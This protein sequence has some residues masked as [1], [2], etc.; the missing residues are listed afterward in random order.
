MDLPGP[1]QVERVTLTAAMHAAGGATTLIAV[2]SPG[3]HSDG[4]G[5][6]YVEYRDTSGWDQGLHPDGTDLSRRAV[7]L[8]RVEAVNQT[9]RCW[10]QGRIL[11]PLEI[12]V[13]AS[14]ARLPLAVRVV[15]VGTPPTW[16]VVELVG[17][18]DRAVFVGRSDKDEVVGFDEQRVDTVETIC[19]RLEARWGNRRVVTSS[20]FS[21]HSYGFGGTGPGTTAPP[22][23][24][25]TVGGQPAGSGTTNLTLNVGPGRGVVMQA[26]VDDA[27]GR[28]TLSNRPEDGRYRVDVVATVTES[29]GGF[30]IASPPEAYEPDGL[31]AGYEHS[32]HQQLDACIREILNDLR[33][34][35]DEIFM[36]PR[37]ALRPGEGDRLQRLKLET[38][39]ARVARFNP[40]VAGE[41]QHLVA[42]RYGALPR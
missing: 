30:P 41:L 2:H 26:A 19:G 22:A 11:V 31:R 34:R 25:W 29:N 37:D 35:P 16:V 15:E 24:R 10:Y 7:V 6:Y 33:V 23:V 4:R 32:I 42:L 14:V 1:G 27:T 20:T 12:D 38:I 5:R 28:L 3:E 21:A 36:P 18:D 17:T 8:H 40:L 13:D 39:V 9:A